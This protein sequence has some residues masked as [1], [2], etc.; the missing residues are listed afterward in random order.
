MTDINPKTVK[1]VR[2]KKNHISKYFKVVSISTFVVVSVLC[3]DEV[4]T[5]L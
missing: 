1:N 4:V 5:F 2:D 3:L